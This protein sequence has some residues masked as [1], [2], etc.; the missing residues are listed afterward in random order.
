M[1]LV[2]HIELVEELC[3]HAFKFQDKHPRYSHGKA[4][5]ET[6]AVCGLLVGYDFRSYYPYYEAGE[7]ACL[8]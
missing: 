1:V 3:I 5:R 8:M 2:R 7:L 4:I 6:M